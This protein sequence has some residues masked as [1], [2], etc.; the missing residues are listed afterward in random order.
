MLE[1]FPVLYADYVEDAFC[2]HTVTSNK[3]ARLPVFCRVRH[4]YTKLLLK[5]IINLKFCVSFSSRCFQESQI[6]RIFGTMINQKLQDFEEDVKALGDL[7]TQVIDFWLAADL[8]LLT[9]VNNCNIR[10]RSPYWTR[11]EV[12]K[13]TRSS[14]LA[15]VSA[16]GYRGVF[17]GKLPKRITWLPLSCSSNL[18]KCRVIVLF[19]ALIVLLST[20]EY[21]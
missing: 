9:K 19:A 15:R 13:V 20:D 12:V 7:M 2:A 11:H 6:K 17:L 8:C 10:P 5:G 18:V 14:G 4:S 16:G 1:R 21:K 3:L